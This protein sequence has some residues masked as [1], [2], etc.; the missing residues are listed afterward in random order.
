MPE[1]QQQ[2]AAPLRRK[3][4]SFPAVAAPPPEPAPPEPIDYAAIAAEVARLLPPPAPVP[5]ETARLLTA[6]L[7]AVPPGVFR[8]IFGLGVLALTL[9][10]AQLRALWGLPER[11]DQVEAQLAEVEAALTRIEGK[12]DSNK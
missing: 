2:Q 9:Y 4:G 11:V 7:A 3:T 1:Q 12:L 5:P 10:G 8:W 6:S